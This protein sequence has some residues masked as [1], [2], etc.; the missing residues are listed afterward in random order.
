MFEWLNPMKSTIF[1]IL[2]KLQIKAS[3]LLDGV[4][5]K[6]YGRQGRNVGTAWRGLEIVISR[7]PHSL[8]DIGSGSGTHAEEFRKS[9][10]KVKTLDFGSSVYSASSTNPP[11]FVGNFYDIQIN[12]K[13][14]CVWASHVLE[15]QPNAGQFLSRCRELIEKDGYI[16]VT[17]PPAKPIIVGGHLSIWNEGLLIY[18]LVRSGFDCLNATVVRHGYN[19]TVIAPLAQ[20]VPQ[21]ATFDSGDLADLRGRLPKSLRWLDEDAF[22]G[23][24]FF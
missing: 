9:G 24:S 8:I 21:S 6:M 12:E 23:G 10:I 2:S 1:G 7:K 13:F 4:N 15:H 22:Y 20:D 11:D 5:Q 19:I 18:N 3:C 16:A 14:E 17:V